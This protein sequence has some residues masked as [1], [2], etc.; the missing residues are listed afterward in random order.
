MKFQKL[1]PILM[2]EAFHFRGIIIKI[3]HSISSFCVLIGANF[4]A[5]VGEN[6]CCI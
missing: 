3:T 1:A 6:A 4:S 5:S 2:L